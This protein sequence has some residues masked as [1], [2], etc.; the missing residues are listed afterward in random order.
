M[1]APNIWKAY[2]GAPT[3]GADLVWKIAEGKPTRSAAS[4]AAETERRRLEEEARA[5]ALGYRGRQGFYLGGASGT[6]GGL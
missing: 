2:G 3:S 6:L 5:S 1:G 4:T